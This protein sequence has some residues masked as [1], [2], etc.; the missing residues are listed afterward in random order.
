M[1][2]RSFLLLFCAAVIVVPAPG[3]AADRAAFDGQVVIHADDEIRT[4]KRSELAAIF[5]GKKSTWDSGRKI[6]PT[7]QPEKNSVT[8]DFLRDVLGKS[9]SQ[10]RAYWKRR[11]FSGGGTVPKPL[12]TSAEV[13]AF[14]ASHEGAI[15]FVEKSAETNDKVV[16]LEIRD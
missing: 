13:I 4:I 9:L 6:I 3:G 5:L 10:Y 16:A 1:G 2:Q 12:R 7:L 8:R 15:G 14:V 11:L